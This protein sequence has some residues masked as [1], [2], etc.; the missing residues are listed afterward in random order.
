MSRRPL[1]SEFLFINSFDQPPS[2]RSQEL[3][4]AAAKAHAASRS[5]PKALRKPNVLFR[6]A[7]TQSEPKK[8]RRK[9]RP[10]EKSPQ[11]P[12]DLKPKDNDG[13]FEIDTRSTGRRKSGNVTAPPD[14]SPQTLLDAG[15]WEPFD[16]FAVIDPSKNAQ[17]L[18]DY[19]KHHFEFFP[20]SASQRA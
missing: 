10:L 4:S 8:E 7:Q 6:D 15:K 5:F 1:R 16:S 3:Q 9:H 19:G 14:S 12:V 18:L 20:D 17:K 2:K 11:T 13:W